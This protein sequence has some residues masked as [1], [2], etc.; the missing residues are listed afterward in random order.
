LP[1]KLP[2]TMLLGDT[3]GYPSGVSHGVTTYYLNVVPPLSREV[4]LTVCMLREA[5]PAARELERAGIKPI[6]L[7]AHRMDP[8]VVRQVASLAKERGCRILHAG[9]IKATLVARIVARLLDAS[10]LVHVHDNKIAP[11]PMRYLHRLFARPT[12]L[13]ICVSRAVGETAQT[14]YYV[15]RDRL[16]VVYNGIDLSRF[17]RIAPDARPRV[18]AELGIPSDAPVLAL[19]GRF[20]PVKGHEEML[21]M[22]PAIAARCPDVVLVMAGDGP[23]RA[24]CESLAAQ[25]DIR[26]HLRFLGQRN[27]VADLLQASDLVVVP[28]QTEGFPLAVVEALAIGRPVVAYDVGGIG[29]A[30]DDGQTGQLVPA[31]DMDAFVA[32]VVSLLDDRAALA[33]YSKRASVAAEKFSIS[34]HIAG[35][36]ECYEEA[37]AVP[38]RPATAS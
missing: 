23:C 3:F 26:S 31:R 38:F 33:A 7:G 8:F 29:E 1:T 35:L 19:I 9:G 25:L 13:G 37:R 21:R 10:V 17:R 27:D 24:A 11:A 6:F 34:S 16:R 20:Y 2:P 28:S 36:L 12:D 32:A 30:V 14:S 4:D 5:H 15:A 18:R 22:M